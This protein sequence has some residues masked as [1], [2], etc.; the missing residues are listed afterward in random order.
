MHNNNEENWTWTISGSKDFKVD[1]S[2]LVFYL[3][4]EAASGDKG[5]A[6]VWREKIKWVERNEPGF[7]SSA[8]IWFTAN[9]SWFLGIL[10]CITGIW[11][12]IKTIQLRRLE[13]I[14]N[15]T[16]QTAPEVSKI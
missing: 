16:V 11:A 8:W 7:W 2:D 10:A 13:L 14:R 15:A 6:D 3:G 4:Y 9:L 1:A 5:E 12:S